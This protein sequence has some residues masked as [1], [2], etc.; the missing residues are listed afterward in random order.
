MNVTDW[1]YGSR[2]F[3]IEST[4]RRDPYVLDDDLH[5]TYTYEPFDEGAWGAAL[6]TVA[7]TSGDGLTPYETTTH[8][9][10]FPGAFNLPGTVTRCGSSTA[11]A[12]CV[13]TT[14][15]WDHGDGALYGVPKSQTFIDGSTEET[16]VDPTCGLVTQTTD[17]AGRVLTRTL[18]TL[19][20]VQTEAFEGALTTTAYDSF[21]R[22]TLTTTDPDVDDGESSDTLTERHFYEDDLSD[23]DKATLTSGGRLELLDVDGWGRPEERR[24]C[25]GAVGGAGVPSCTGDEKVQ[26]WVRLD[27]GRVGWEILP[28]FDGED[29]E[30]I[31]FTTD[32]AGRVVAQVSPGANG[33]EALTTWQYAPGVTVRTDALGVEE[34]AEFDF[35]TEE[36]LLNGLSRRLVVRDAYGRLL[37]DTDATGL[38]REIAYD[39]LHRVNVET[40]LPSVGD[41]SC[42]AAASGAP[43]VTSCS[44]L[45]WVTEHDLIGR[46]VTVTDPL[47][48]ASASTFDPVGRLAATWVD[49]VT[50]VDITTTDRLGAVAAT[51]TTVDETGEEVTTTHDG[52]GRVITETTLAGTTFTT[53]GADGLPVSVTDVDGRTRYFERDVW[54][55][56]LAICAP[57]GW[58]GSAC[59]APLVRHTLDAQGRVLTS[60][61]ADGVTWTAERGPGGV[62][63]RLLQGTI[64][65]EEHDYDILGRPV[66]SLVEGVER[67]FVYD[68]LGR[69]SSVTLGGGARVT[70]L[71]SCG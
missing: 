34:R 63:Q 3:L 19:C 29:F 40:L 24:S 62:L 46:T 44:T 58:D 6:A 1:E 31:A 64:V 28:H 9:D 65:L 21:N 10:F 18:D 67:A 11:S 39:A 68:S 49:G 32:H 5:T 15:V 66:W 26:A 42:A 59:A 70:T 12:N 25:P 56:V 60:T 53:Y 69:V 27:D 7:V 35:L 55:D 47:G 2:G 4:Q 48:V 50:L 41:T 71:G 14:L 20:R 17:R 38:T 23:A 30:A 54:G 61:D 52:L 8:A 13:T 45:T 43:S 33:A 57:S 51:T 36:R 37:S 22:V 16:V